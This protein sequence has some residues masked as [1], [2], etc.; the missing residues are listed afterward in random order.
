LAGPNDDDEAMYVGDDDNNEGYEDFSAIENNPRQDVVDDDDDDDVIE[1]TCALTR[2]LVIQRDDEWCDENNENESVC[3]GHASVEPEYVEPRV[4]RSSK[5]HSAQIA[6][7]VPK[8]GTCVRDAAIEQ[9]PLPETEFVWK[10]VDLKNAVDEEHRELLLAYNDSVKNLTKLQLYMSKQPLLSRSNVYL[11]FCEEAVMLQREVELRYL[12]NCEAYQAIDPDTMQRHGYICQAIPPQVLESHNRKII[13]G[14][15]VIDGKD[16]NGNWPVTEIVAEWI[17]DAMREE[18]DQ[19]F[20]DDANFP[21]QGDS[22][23]NGQSTVKSF[24]RDFES[25]CA[26]HNVPHN[27]KLALLDCFHRHLPEVRLG[28]RESKAGNNVHDF[29]K[30]LLK[31]WRDITIDVCP[32]NCILFVGE[33]RW[34]IKCPCGEYRFSKCGNNGKCTKGGLDCS[35]YDN[36]SHSLRSSYQSIAYRFGEYIHLVY[37]LLLFHNCQATDNQIILDVQK[38]FGWF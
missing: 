12:R 19:R 13:K 14:K 11:Y 37:L 5:L 32:K 27:G 30:Y 33:H 20:P 38:F 28:I 29:N 17:Q 16:E 18:K 25:T 3:S 15:T 4:L 21:L 22:C 35:P 8:N 1:T 24:I 6:A 31:D 7:N 26:V 34:K 23:L 36:P 2:S 9:F 10:A